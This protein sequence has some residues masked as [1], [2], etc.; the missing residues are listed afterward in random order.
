MYP[1]HLLSPHGGGMLRD[2]S[3]HS[4]SP[5]QCPVLS[6]CLW[7]RSAGQDVTDDRRFI[8]YLAKAQCKGKIFTFAIVIL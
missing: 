8:Q 3:T 5:F 6:L 1:V 2:V 7:T 4:M